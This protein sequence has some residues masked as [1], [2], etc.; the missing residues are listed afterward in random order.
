MSTTNLLNK[1]FSLL[2]GIQVA[3]KTAIISWTPV[4]IEMTG[5]GCGI[6]K[7]RKP[8]L[9]HVTTRA[10]AWKRVR[11]SVVITCPLT[12]HVIVPK[13][14]GRRPVLSVAVVARVTVVVA[15]ARGRR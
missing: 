11:P 6:Q 14:F 1:E 3:T 2:G 12:L 15:V 9:R 5:N 8:S 7:I 4:L 10:P 13:M